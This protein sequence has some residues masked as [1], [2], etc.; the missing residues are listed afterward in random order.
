MKVQSVAKGIRISPRK[1]SVVASLVRGRSVNDAIV[2]LQHTPRRAAPL[3]AKAINSA[4][5]NARH[6]ERADIDKLMI[7]DLQV[8]HGPRM[9]RFFTAARGSANKYMKRTSHVKVVVSGPDSKKV[10]PSK[11]KPASPAS[12]STKKET[13]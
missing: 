5:A 8:M 7:E 2:I 10:E 13:K 6:N 12:K 11:V 4:A 9:K 1:M 3:L